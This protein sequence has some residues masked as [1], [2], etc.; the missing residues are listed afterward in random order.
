MFVSFSDSLFFD[1]NFPVFTNVR[2]SMNEKILIIDD[3]P[4]ILESL[5]AV[6]T[7]EGFRVKRA[8]GGEKAIELF[9]SES[10]DLVITD[11]RMPR[12]DGL[13]VIKQLKAWNEDVGIIVLTGF[14]S[15][16]NAVRA[17][18]NNGAFDFLTK[19]LEDI[20][21]MLITV[22]NALEHQKLRRENKNLIKELSQANVQ[23][24]QEIE[25]R[26]KSEETVVRKNKVLK[27]INRIFQ[28]TLIVES[29][30]ELSRTY[31]DVVAELT[32]SKL[33]WI[34][35]VN[36][37][38]R[39]DLAV[40]NSSCW[41]DENMSLSKAIT[42]MKDMEIVG[43]SGRVLKSE[44]SL[45]INDLASDP[46]SRPIA[47]G[48]PALNSFL[49]VPLKYQGKTI[50]LIALANK[51]S[52][53]DLRD[54]RD[55][56]MLSYVFMTALS[57]KRAEDQIKYLARHDNLTGL[58]TRR[59]FFDRLAKALSLAHQDQHIVSLLYIDLDGFKSMNDKF[60]Y[61]IG[62]SILKEVAARLKS[63]T[64]KT[65]TVARLGGDEFAV[66]LPDV[67][68]KQEA[69]TIAQK[70]VTAIAQPMSI[71]NNR[72]VVSASIGISSYPDDSQ[73]TDTLIQNADLAMYQVKQRGKNH[74]LFFG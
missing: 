67:Q 28:D 57:R 12:V 45:I 65:D 70:I 35:E 16:E 21:Q 40:L 46:D 58:L 2:G 26:K 41:D 59:L 33:S 50:G 44:Q 4:D 64:R 23:L 7:S 52:G 62:D 17:M 19:P 54:R 49:G 13:E 74:Y 22:S 24:K 9:R 69:E 32:E 66:I 18:R 38:G 34:G 53:Y 8:L 30:G 37:A 36:Q 55:V 63:C 11:I 39:I 15:I 73:N 20:N 25:Q 61:A 31:L 71:Q 3:E 56:E 51:E 43:I 1:P 27:G 10:F 68:N 60:G 6:L 5:D 48:F 42:I 47:E 29:E 14:P 72:C